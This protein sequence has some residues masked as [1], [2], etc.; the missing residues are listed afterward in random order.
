MLVRVQGGEKMPINL[1]TMNGIDLS[2][3][4]LQHY[5]GKAKDPQYA[6]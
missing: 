1:R 4:N 3:L 6:V 2:T 5:D